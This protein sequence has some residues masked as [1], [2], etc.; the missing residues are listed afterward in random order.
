MVAVDD[1]PEAAAAAA[2]H[3]GRSS[4]LGVLDGLVEDLRSGRSG[5]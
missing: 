5:I 2:Q 4:E 3:P 1:F